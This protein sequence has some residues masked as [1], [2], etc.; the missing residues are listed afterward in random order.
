MKRLSMQLAGLLCF[1]LLFAGCSR[2]NQASVGQIENIHTGQI[3]YARNIQLRDDGKGTVLGAI[4]GGLVGNQFGPGGSGEKTAATIGGVLLG[5]YAGNQI[6]QN[7]GQ[8]LTINLGDGRQIVT[9][10]RIDDSTPTSFRN[11]DNVRVYMRGSTV[12]RV[13][14]AGY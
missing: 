12:T 6:N 2:H 5:G 4:A 13:L 10:V 7:A 1:L 9:V 14:L 11:G 3:V 8:E